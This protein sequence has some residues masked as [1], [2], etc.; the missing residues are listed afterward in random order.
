MT[1]THAAAMTAVAIVGA[2]IAFWVLS[3]L[4]GIFV[5]FLKIAV[6]VGLIGGT[7]WLVSHFRHH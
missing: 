2:V 7:F 6:V 3:S 1:F 4:V 5:F